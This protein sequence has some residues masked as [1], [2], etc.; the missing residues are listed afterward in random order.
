MGQPCIDAGNTGV[1][2]READG[3]REDREGE[4][5]HDLVCPQRDDQ[6]RM[7]RG[8]GRAGDRR[9]DDP[10]R[11]RDRRGRVDALHRPEPHHGAD[12]HHPLDAEVEHAR[13]LGQQLAECAV[14]QRSA[15]RNAA[16]D[17]HHQQ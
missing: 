13:A 15:V 10:G 16:R 1:V 14:E 9:H 7:D 4:T 5:R 6:E 11:E 3:A 8:H 2:G 17:Q 12:E